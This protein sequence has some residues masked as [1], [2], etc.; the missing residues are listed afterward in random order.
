MNCLII[1]MIIA[2]PLL[3]EM[4]NSKEKSII[5]PAVYSFIFF[6]LLIDLIKNRAHTKFYQLSFWICILCIVFQL[7]FLFIALV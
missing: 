5:Q 4:S 3:A 7:W 6:L 2:F 1:M